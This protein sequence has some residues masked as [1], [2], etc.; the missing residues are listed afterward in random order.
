PAKERLHRVTQGLAPW[1]G[2]ILT[3]GQSQRWYERISLSLRGLSKYLNCSESFRHVT[4]Q[5]GRR[6]EQR[7]GQQRPG[8]AATNQADNRAPET[9]LAQLPIH[10]VV[11]GHRELRVDQHKHKNSCNSVD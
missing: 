1:A 2:M 3:F 11:G 6:D 9:R 7:L 5:D 4:N 8:I 10:H